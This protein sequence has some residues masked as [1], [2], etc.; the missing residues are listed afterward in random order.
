MKTMVLRAVGGLFLLL[1][2][3]GIFLPLLPT[4]P[5]VLCAAWCFGKASPALARRLENSAYFGQ[6]IQ[7]YRHGTG[8]CPAARMQALIFLWLTLGISAFFWHSSHGRLLL[9]VVGIGVTIHLCTIKTRREEERPWKKD[10]NQSS[11]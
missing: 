3:I 9:A 10:S 6:Y 8:I 2:G 5:F 1:G 7:N 4:T 11:K